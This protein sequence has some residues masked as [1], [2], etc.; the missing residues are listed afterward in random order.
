[1]TSSPSVTVTLLPSGGLAIGLPGPFGLDRLIPLEER[2]AAAAPSPTEVIK[3]VLLALQRGEE[4]IGTQAAPTR[5]QVEHWQRH[6]G[7]WGFQ[8]RCPFCLAEE[9]SG[10]SAGRASRVK[11]EKKLGG[12]VVVRRIAEGETKARVEGK[13]KGRVSREARRAAGLEMISK[14]SSKDLGF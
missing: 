1:M 11:S 7:P 5:A 6:V 10:R 9:R 3:M 14:G 8:P 4:A 13:E 2:K 12:G